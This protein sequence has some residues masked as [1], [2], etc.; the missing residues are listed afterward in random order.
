[1]TPKEY[2]MV[3]VKT[4]AEPSLFALLKLGSGHFADLLTF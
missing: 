2:S 4:E 3:T 1:M